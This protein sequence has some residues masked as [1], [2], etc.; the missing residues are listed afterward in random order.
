VEVLA[1]A[2]QTLLLNKRPSAITVSVNGT[3]LTLAGY[4]VRVLD[5]AVP[6]GPTPTAVATATSTPSP[7]A[8]TTSLATPRR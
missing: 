4:D 8:M 7:L 1:S 2:T 3:L 5:A 6:P